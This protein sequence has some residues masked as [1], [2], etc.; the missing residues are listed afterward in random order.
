[1]KHLLNWV[2]I[3]VLDMERAKKFYSA[4]LDI[5]FQDM[6]LEDMLY[7]FFPSEDQYN[8]G[9]LVQSPFYK[10]CAEGVLIYL[11]G[12]EDLNI[13]LEKV[14][15]AGGNVVMPKTLISDMAGYAGMFIDTEGNRIGVH[16]MK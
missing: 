2:E 1:M 6:P 14:N 16:S 11:N 13:V 8:S 10:P 9:A 3:P 15:K 7:A 4:I 5:S 12:G